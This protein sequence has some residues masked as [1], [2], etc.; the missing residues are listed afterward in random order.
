[1]RSK[2]KYSR[3]TLRAPR[4]G[5]DCRAGRIRAADNLVQNLVAQDAEFLHLQNAGFS[6]GPLPSTFTSR[7][8]RPPCMFG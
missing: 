6:A 4:L 1:M 3:C 7:W 8:T 5:V 2:S